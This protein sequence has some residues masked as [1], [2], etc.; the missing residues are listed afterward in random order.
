[1]KSNKLFDEEVMKMRAEAQNIHEFT[2]ELGR[3][4]EEPINSK[5]ELERIRGLCQN[6]RW[7]LKAICEHTKEAEEVHRDWKVWRTVT[8]GLHNSAASAVDA[9]AEASIEFSG[10]GKE[11]FLSFAELTGERKEVDLIAIEPRDLGLTGDS[12]HH[13]SMRRWGL[14][15]GL[16]LCPLEVGVVLAT[17]DN[18][19]KDLFFFPMMEPVDIGEGP[20]QGC[21][22]YL[23][24]KYLSFTKRESCCTFPNS[25]GAGGNKDRFVFVLPRE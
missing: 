23:A 11:K 8:I 4:F 15:F 18:L 10:W 1:M 9:L 12:Y 3:L 6:M 16:E 21:S 2:S 13:I 5:K 14:L 22:W 25:T 24:Q 17:Q 20:H 19:E 7:P